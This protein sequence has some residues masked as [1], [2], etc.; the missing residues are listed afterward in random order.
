MAPDFFVEVALVWAHELFLA[1]WRRVH[2]AANCTSCDQ[3]SFSRNNC[4]FPVVVSRVVL[5]PLIG[6]TY[7]P[8][9]LQPSPFFKTV[10]RRIERAGFDL[11]QVVGL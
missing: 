4:A 7:P 3:R 5:R 8:L 2:D 1:R 9:G 6:L 11:E 10:Q